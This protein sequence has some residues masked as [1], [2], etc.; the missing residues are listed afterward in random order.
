MTDR[1]NNTIPSETVTITI[2][3]Q[4]AITQQPESQTIELGEP[5]NLSV[6]AEGMGLQYQ[7]YFKKAGEDS[8]TE[9]SE[10]TDASE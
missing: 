5:L 2:T 6:T 10:H 9:W 7:W 8:F 3:R 1:L 4:L